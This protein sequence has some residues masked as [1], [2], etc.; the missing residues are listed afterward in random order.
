MIN[1]QKSYFE[2]DNFI[3]LPLPKTFNIFHECYLRRKLSWSEF[4][5]HLIAGFAILRLKVQQSKE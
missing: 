3:E 1:L 2:A 4:V 5:N